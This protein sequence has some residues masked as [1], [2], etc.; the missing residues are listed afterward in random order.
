MYVSIT[1]PSTDLDGRSEPLLLLTCYWLVVLTDVISSYPCPYLFL[2]HTLFE[3]P[4]LR[5]PLLNYPTRPA[6]GPNG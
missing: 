3:A 5:L 4:P 2:T 6:T 1:Y